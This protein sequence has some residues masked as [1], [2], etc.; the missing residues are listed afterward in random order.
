MIKGIVFD[1]DGTLLEY[2][3]FWIPVAEG[4]TAELLNEH[5][6]DISLLSPMLDSIHAYDGR[7][8]VLCYG[9]YTDICN[10]MNE[11]LRLL[12]QD[13]E[14]FTL[15]EVEHAYAENIK[16]GRL[17]PVCDNI[18]EVFSALHA[19]GYKIGL[20]TSDIESI[21][22]M[23]LKDLGIYEYFDVILA[24]DGVHPSK[25]DPYHMNDFC[26]RFGL[27]PSEVMMVGD[28][29][30]DMKFAENSG[31]VGVGVAKDPLDARMLEPKAYAVLND[32]SY[33]SEFIKASSL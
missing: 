22:A 6:Y 20:V 9:T 31:A 5:G 17:I 8:G 29:L 3:E 16:N 19:E 11:R 2:E 32:V 26:E 30:T 33:I 14:L 4:A 27:M 13:A 12:R 15:S 25:P 1:K 7:R 28:T 24:D 21:A 10:A 23:C 18:K